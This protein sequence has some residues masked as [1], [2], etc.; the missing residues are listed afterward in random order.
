[1]RKALLLASVVLLSAIA[2]APAGADPMLAR[3]ARAPQIHRLASYPAVPVPPSL[4]P[5]AAELAAARATAVAYWH[6]PQPPCGRERVVNA[7][8]AVPA[9][10]AEADF[11]SCAIVL[12]TTRD[13]R[14]WPAILCRVYVHEFGHLVLGPTY[15]QASNPASPAH[16]PDPNN[17]MYGQ[18]VTAAQYAAQTRSVGCPS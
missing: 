2:A 15:F 14:S 12:S 18:P 13:W 8:P 3:H 9:W 7:A 5:T 4:L 1:V 10:L 16:S 11:G 6:V 17:I